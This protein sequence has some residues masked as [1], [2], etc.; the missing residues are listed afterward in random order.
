MCTRLVY[1]ICFV[2]VLA[3]LSGSAYAATLLDYDFSDGS[4][5]TVTDLSG[6]GNHGTLVG[7]S[8]TSGGA[9]VFNSSEGWV[10]G[11]GLSFLDDGVRSYVETPLNLSA[12]PG[13]FTLEFQANYAGAS[14]WVPAIGSNASGCCAESIF[15]GINSNL[16]DVE[17][18]LQDSGGPVGP[19]PW[20]SPPD[21]TLHHL[22][23]VYDVVTDGV[24]VF[25]DGTS[26]GTA[27]RSAANMAGVTT[28]F[29]VAN[30]GWA[31]SEQWDGILFGVAI[32][33]QKLGPGSFVIPNRPK[34][35]EKASDPDPDDETTDVPVGV[36]LSWTP[37]DFAN[38]H[39]VYFGTSFDDVNEATKASPEYKTTKSFG[40][41]SYAPGLLDFETAY[42][43]R[44]D[45]VN[46]PPHQ[47]TVFKGDIW[48]FTT[49]PF[50]Y[51][52]TDV[53]TTASSSQME[54]WGPQNTVNGSGLDADDLH[55]TEDTDMWLSSATGPQPTWIQYEFDKSYKL[56]QMW[57]WNYNTLFEPFV[58]F[59]LKDVTIEYST[60]GTDW[61]DLGGVPQFTRAPGT[62]GYAHN[63]TVD[64]DGVVAKYVRLTATSNYSGGLVDQYGL[65]EVRFLYIPVWPREPDPP[66][67][68]TG[69]HPD[70]TLSWRAGREA[71]THK[72]YLSSNR[73]AVTNDTVAAIP[74]TEASYDAGTLEL[75]KTYYWKINEV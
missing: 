11:G 28:Q 48:Q 43:W 50:A 40:D 68:A 9:G 30:T 15:F 23:L 2:L 33:D 17:V 22:A 70:I 4:G 29:R 53:N 18:R 60:N 74:V 41:E 72:L 66:D 12:L 56:H 3:L 57:V 27:T 58:G 25:V 59:G 19:H 39:D 5:T 49:E 36:V 51:P 13:D 34:V 10:T 26:I 47:S 35:Q 64:F 67:G 65:S 38:T 14:S 52:I 54:G 6:S 73:E 7:F 24:E 45:E 37:G 55:S 69:L 61:T 21:T 20:S 46:A 44:I 8:N 42:Y 32:S 63:T 16:T 31:D 62:D 71:A 1:L 75:G